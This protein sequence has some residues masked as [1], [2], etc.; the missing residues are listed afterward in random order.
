MCDCS[1]A[2]FG[3]VVDTVARAIAMQYGGAT[4]QPEVPEARRIVFRIG[5][6]L[7]DVVVDD[8][9]LL[10]DGVN[11]AARL[12][13]LCEPGGVLISHTA[14]DQLKGK[15][16][17]PLEFIGEQHLK[18]IAEPV[19]AYRVRLDGTRQARWRS[20]LQRSRRKLLPTLAVLLALVLAAGATAWWLRPVEP[21]LAA[22]PS[23]AVLPFDS[24]SGDET[25]ERLAD[26]ITE[27][28]I[29]DLARFRDIS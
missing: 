17:L 1:F 12:E 14:Y 29:T 20:R 19:R 16:G 26:G 4:R 2:V 10:G 28:I 18:N 13:Q 7:G 6:N 8:G 22:K 5:I 15:L 9:D 21:A 23:I 25:T 11:V 24:Y 27:D 3:S